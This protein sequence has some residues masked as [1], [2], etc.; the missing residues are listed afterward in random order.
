MILDELLPVILEIVTI[1][2]RLLLLSF[3]TFLFAISF[4]FLP[5][6]ISIALL[7]FLIY[8]WVLLFMACSHLK[9][10]YVYFKKTFDN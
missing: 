6:F 5:A 4:L 2:N 1:I 8:Q 10:K 3:S 9:K 7:L